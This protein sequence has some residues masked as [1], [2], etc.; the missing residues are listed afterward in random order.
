MNAEKKVYHIYSTDSNIVYEHFD[1]QKLN[2]GDFLKFRQYKKKV[3][4]EVKVFFVAYIPA[5]THN[6]AMLSG[7]WTSM[8]Q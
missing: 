4:N 3:K 2:K 8:A 1:D 7:A 5:S 6:E